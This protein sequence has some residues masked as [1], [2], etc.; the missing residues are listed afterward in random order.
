[1]RW[2]ALACGVV[3]IGAA[4]LWWQLRGG[5]AEPSSGAATTPV[6][7]ARAAPRGGPTRLAPDTSGQPPPAIEVDEP[8][9]DAPIPRDSDEFY[10]E[11]DRS[12]SANL[13]RAASACYKGGKQRKQ[14]LRLLLRYQIAAG[15]V[16]VHDVRVDES[17]LDDPALER[18]MVDAVAQA[19]WD[20][21]RMP[22]W[23]TRIGEDE[24]ILIRI[25]GLNR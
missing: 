23:Q 13:R 22:D 11:I 20:A 24:Q 4:L 1:M 8:D 14:K 17:T 2:L 16:T 3:A 5:R 7:A 21:P 12:Y 9:E 19:H 15:K 18:C 25:E 10:E 6:A